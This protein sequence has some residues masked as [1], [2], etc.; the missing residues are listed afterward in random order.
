MLNVSG[1]T[2]LDFLLSKGLTISEI[3]RLSGVSRKTI[4]RIQSR[5]V[6]LKKPMTKKTAGKLIGAF[7]EFRKAEQDEYEV[8]KELGL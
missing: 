4:Y 7:N 2:A 1:K 8:R 3:S 6:Q 5:A